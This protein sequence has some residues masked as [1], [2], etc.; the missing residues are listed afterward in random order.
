MK[1]ENEPAWI[2]EHFEKVWGTSDWQGLIGRRCNVPGT[3][4]ATFLGIGLSG[5]DYFL[6]VIRVPDEPFLILVH[7]SLIIPMHPTSVPRL[8]DLYPELGTP[9][10]SLTDVIK[11]LKILRAIDSTALVEPSVGTEPIPA[12]G[13]A[14]CRRLQLLSKDVAGGN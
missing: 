13:E 2:G 12:N 1:K 8:E 9:L 14:R 3:G 6:A 11:R 5:E 4:P 10:T 7:P